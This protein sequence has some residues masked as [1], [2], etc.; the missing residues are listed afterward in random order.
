[1]KKNKIETELI[2]NIKT[3]YKEM[4]D[5][6]KKMYGVFADYK[7]L[8][9]TMKQ[10]EKSENG[11]LDA[12]KK[13]KEQNEELSSLVS[14]EPLDTDNLQQ[15]LDK[16][17]TD[18]SY[19]V[20]DK[21][22][23]IWAITK[24]KIHLEKIKIAREEV[25]KMVSSFVAAILA[26]DKKQTE[27]LSEK[28]YSILLKPVIPFVS[29]DRIGVIP[30][31]PLY[32]LLFAAISSKEQYLVDGF[33]IFYLPN[34]GMIKYVLKKQMPQEMKVLAFAN[35]DLDEKQLEL[36]YTKTEVENIEKICHKQLFFKG[37]KQQKLK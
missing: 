17:T 37:T 33:S 7:A 19:Y 25:A 35:P 34:T 15:L 26:K 36:S 14:V 29:G 12:I 27:S 1:L 18:F 31:G 5:G 16:N 6:Y 11:R 22:L 13:I 32:W 21:I 2:G 20:T 8:K 30:H 4:T 24:D 9:E 3:N 23:Y 28:I 10:I